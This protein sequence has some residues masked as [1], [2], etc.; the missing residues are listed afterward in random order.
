MATPRI[1]KTVN[2]EST[3][4]RAAA[5]RVVAGIF[6]NHAVAISWA[7]PNE[8][9]F[10]RS[11]APTPLIAEL[12]TRAVFMFYDHPPLG[13][14]IKMSEGWKKDGNIGPVVCACYSFAKFGAIIQKSHA[15]PTAGKEPFRRAV[16]RKHEVLKT[17]KSSAMERNHNNK[18]LLYYWVK[19]WRTR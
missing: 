14:S 7:P 18:E 15:S 9:F 10:T 1:I 3:H 2:Q 19:I 16:F 12:T 4:W 13:E 5:S 8:P 6:N 11:A 17:E